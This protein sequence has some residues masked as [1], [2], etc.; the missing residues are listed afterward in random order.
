MI[1]N[2][3]FQLY[4]YFFHSNTM[5]GGSLTIVKKKISFNLILIDKN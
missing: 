4:V 5:Q 2:R 1:T 3:V